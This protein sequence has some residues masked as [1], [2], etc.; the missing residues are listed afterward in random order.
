VWINTFCI[1]ANYSSSCLSIHNKGLA[2]TQ[3][4]ASIAIPGVFPPVV[5]NNQLHIDGG[6]VDNLPIEAMYQQPVRH[7]I[8][9][10]VTAQPEHWVDLT[11]IPTA[12]QMF[13][14]KI[15]KR[16]KLGLPSLTTLLVNSMVLNSRQKQELT[17]LQVALYLEMDLGKF[18]F[19]DGN[20][21]R[22][23][24]GLGYERTQQALKDM[25]QEEQFWGK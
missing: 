14:N 22:E 15:T 1:S 23:L 20:K 11:E 3:V 25:P 7:V 8:A 10:S 21:W 18:D 17:K 2:R 6:V 24:M 4:E 5:I 13:W 9:I 16:P 19:L 12:W